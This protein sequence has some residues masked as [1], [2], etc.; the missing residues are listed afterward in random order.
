MSGLQDAVNAYHDA[1]V[2]GTAGSSESPR[3]RA[4][5]SS[6]AREIDQIA[7]L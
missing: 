6:Q 3:W 2:A 1:E 7:G 4:E 5:L